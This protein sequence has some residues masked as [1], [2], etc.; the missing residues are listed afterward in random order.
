MTVLGT[1]VR[2]RSYTE[3]DQRRGKATTWSRQTYYAGF[4]PLRGLS[5]PAEAAIYPV[6]HRPVS[7][8]GMEDTRREMVWG[9]EQN[10][11]AGYFSSRTMAQ[12]VVVEPQSSTAAIRVTES[13]DGT[14]PEVVNELG[15][16]VERLA[17]CDSQGD[18]FE[19]VGLASGRKATAAKMDTG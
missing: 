1:R 3:L 15:M 16:E 11:V 17:L 7:G 6:E 19:I 13:K 12:F 9:E 5:F 18:L 14:P 10:L 2:L 8:S 4:A